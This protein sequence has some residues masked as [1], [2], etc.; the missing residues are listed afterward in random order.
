MPGGGGGKNISVVEDENAR[1]QTRA[2][3]S[4]TQP[5]EPEIVF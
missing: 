3:Y 5:P 1:N 2:V 4:T